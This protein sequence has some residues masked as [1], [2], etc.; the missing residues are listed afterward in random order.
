MTSK[1][2]TKGQFLA[3][4]ILRA[5]IFGVFKATAP[6]SLADPDRF[7]H[8]GLARLESSA[9]T[10]HTLPQADDVGWGTS[11]VDKEFLFHVLTRSAYR[12]GG[13]NAVVDL[14]PVLVAAIFLILYFSILPWAETWS[15]FSIL[16]A[17]TLLSPHFYYRMLLLRPHL[18]GILCFVVL[19]VGLVRG[20]PVLAFVGGLC[21]GLGYHAY[22]V[23]GMALALAFL[24][25]IRFPAWKRPFLA[26]LGG[27]AL[28]VVVNPYFP[29]TLQVMFLVIGESGNAQLNRYLN[30]GAELMPLPVADY[31]KYYALHWIV[32]GACLY[33]VLFPFEKKPWKSDA[34]IR[35]AFLGVLSAAFAAMT[36]VSPRTTEYLMPTIVLLVASLLSFRSTNGGT[37]TK[38][39]RAGGALLALHL[40]LGW[41]VFAVTYADPFGVPKPGLLQARTALEALSKLSANSTGKKIFNCEWDLGSYILY[42]RPDMRAVDM[43]AP[44]FLLLSNADK[45]IKRLQLNYGEATDVYTTVTREFQSQYV[46]CKSPSVIAA[47]DRDSR[48]R[49]LYPEKGVAP[50]RHL[51]FLYEVN[52][53][54]C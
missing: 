19:L 17:F 21:F 27:L 22:F 10:L 1:M 49:R 47:M 32:V 36:A 6:T 44:D 26:G 28:G 54:Q 53:W 13:E 46:L 52:L 11:F 5:M 33:A 35:T 2:P 7:F 38:A 40:F 41:G 12:I 20:R 42:A 30:T 31:V 48:F 18:M 43:V 8:L 9:G 23:P 51:V 24:V 15:S 50:A 14:V 16:L 3:S 4:A 45:A 37:L 34:G 29:D 39:W 25:A